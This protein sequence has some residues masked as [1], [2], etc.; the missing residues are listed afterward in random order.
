[1]RCH[2]NACASLAGFEDKPFDITGGGAIKVGAGLVEKEQLWRADQG[3]GKGE[4]L[5]LASRK[6]AGALVLVAGETDDFKPS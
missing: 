4:F 3:A 6:L 1:M 5:A 2:E